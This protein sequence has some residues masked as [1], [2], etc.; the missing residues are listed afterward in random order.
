MNT[1][2]YSI[3]KPEQLLYQIK[4]AAKC[5]LVDV[6]NESKVLQIPKTKD[7]RKTTAAVTEAIE[8]TL[9]GVINDAEILGMYNEVAEKKLDIGSLSTLTSRS[10]L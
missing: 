2:G 1:A 7:A 8:E 10:E 9:G 5:S 4:E 3:N 6:I